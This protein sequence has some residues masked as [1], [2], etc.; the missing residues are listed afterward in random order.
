MTEEARIL[1]VNPKDLH[2]LVHLDDLQRVLAAY[3]LLLKSQG[4]N[5]A[6]RKH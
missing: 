3:F 1:H 2:E 5:H 6:E 4:E